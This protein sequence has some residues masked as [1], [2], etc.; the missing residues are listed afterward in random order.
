MAPRRDAS[1][2]ATIRITWAGVYR[3]RIKTFLKI[4]WDRLAAGVQDLKS[5]RK[6]PI[7]ILGGTESSSPPS[8]AGR[9]QP[10]K[11]R[12]PDA[13]PSPSL[14]PPPASTIVRVQGGQDKCIL[15]SRPL[16]TTTPEQLSQCQIDRNHIVHAA[17]G[18]Q[19]NRGRCPSCKGPLVPFDVTTSAAAS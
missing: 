2:G 3:R 10:I 16:I 19:L 7:R 18:S 1:T 6:K 11:I 14:P 15:C 12:R 17:C 8:G 5:P 13:V 4:A 9:P